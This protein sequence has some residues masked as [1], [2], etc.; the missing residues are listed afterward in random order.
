MMASNVSFSSHCD[1]KVCRVG[2]L[3]ADLLLLS[4]ANGDAADAVRHGAHEAAELCAR[5]PVYPAAGQA[6]ATPL[7]AVFRG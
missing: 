6:E 2:D 1:S 4:A 5:Y 7:E 3:I